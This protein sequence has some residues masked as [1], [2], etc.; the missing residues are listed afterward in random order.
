MKAIAALYYKRSILPWLLLPIAGIYW[1]IIT[2][3]K[4][5][6]QKKIYKT[7][8]ASIPVIVVGN[9]TLGG[10]GKTPLVIALTKYLQ[11]CGF[12]P[13]VISRGY[14]A[15]SKNFPAVI[16]DT[17]T[18][19]EVGDEPFLIYKNTKVPVVIDP[20]RARAAKALEQ[21]FNCS[22][23]LCD[24]GL[25][26]YA[27][28]RDIEIVLVDT[29]RKFGNGFLFPAGPL[30]ESV[31][32]LRDVDFILCNGK[33]I[34]Q[35]SFTMTLSAD[36]IK[37][38]ATD[39]MVPISFFKDKPL[40]AIAGIGNP[41]RFFDTLT[42]LGLK[43]K[44]QPMPDHYAYRQSDFDDNTLYLMTEKDAV[45]CRAFNNENLFYLPVT[46]DLEKNFLEKLIKLL[47]KKVA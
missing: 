11:Q 17:K 37:N 14:G 16:D 21:Q 45:K 32:R 39:E 31:K 20:V 36:A 1:V 46:A 6:Y 28:E 33:K 15:K 3:R 27:L 24:D 30:R 23:I 18:V 43:F 29:Q 34:Y 8:K 44:K 26:H 19:M 35:N 12:K 9:L 10:T 47:S 25:Q 40:I 2:I 4:W 22:V 41:Q 42:Q 38:L 7:Y 5:F 13:G